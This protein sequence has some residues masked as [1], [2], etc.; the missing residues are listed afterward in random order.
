MDY[1]GLTVKD[2]IECGN[3]GHKAIINK[4]IDEVM[5]NEQFIRYSYESSEKIA[6]SKAIIQTVAVMIEQ[7]NRALLKQLKEIGLQ[8]DSK[9]IK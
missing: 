6:L 8:L 4:V 3:T 5:Q 1:I 9:N 2:L 7:N